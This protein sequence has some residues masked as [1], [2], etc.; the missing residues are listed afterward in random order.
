MKITAK[1]R[2]TEASQNQYRH[3]N[4]LYFRY[5][6][7]RG[8]RFFFKAVDTDQKFQMLLSDKEAENFNLEIN[9]TYFINN[10]DE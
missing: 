1:F 8:N 7:R 2:F 3:F 4:I 5:Y 9:K 10:L 6:L